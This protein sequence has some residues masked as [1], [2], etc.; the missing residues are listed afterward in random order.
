[1]IV[2]PGTA[3]VL[4]AWSCFSESCQTPRAFSAGK[5]RPRGDAYYRHSTP[6]DCKL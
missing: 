1:M 4:V 5:W 3:C 2:P 6:C